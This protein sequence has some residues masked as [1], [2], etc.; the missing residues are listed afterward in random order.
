MTGAVHF[1]TVPGPSKID[2][3]CFYIIIIFAGKFKSSS[4]QYCS[5]TNSNEANLFITPTI[6][7]ATYRQSQVRRRSRLRP[8]LLCFYLSNTVKNKQTRL[9][10]PH[11]DKGVF[12]NLT[13]EIGHFPKNLITTS[14]L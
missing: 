9:I 11:I 12:C 6:T 4:R 14:V 2:C 13:P 7:M 5:N 10:L 3:T 1:S 8:L